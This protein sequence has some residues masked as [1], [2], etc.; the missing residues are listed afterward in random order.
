MSGEIPSG[1]GAMVQDSEKDA[2]GGE[3]Q[4]GGK[5]AKQLL[6]LAELV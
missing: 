5:K 3:K 1:A 2:G 4:Q 6:L